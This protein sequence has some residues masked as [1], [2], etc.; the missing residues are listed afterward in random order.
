MLPDQLLDLLQCALVLLRGADRARCDDVHG[1]SP[2]TA[3]VCI[4]QISGNIGLVCRRVSP[5]SDD[6]CPALPSAVKSGPA[7]D[8][9]LRF[10]A[11]VLDELGVSWFP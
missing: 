9:T 5:S 3:I 11:E 7:L 1:V 8:W 10:L 6:L 2:D 4:M